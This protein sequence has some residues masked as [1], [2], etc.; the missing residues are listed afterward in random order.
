MWTVVPAIYKVLTAPHIY[1]SIFS[2]RQLTCYWC[3]LD[4]LMRLILHSWCQIQRTSSN[5]CYVNCGPGHIQS[6]YSSAYLGFNIQLK[7]APLLFEVSRRINERITAKLV[8]TTAQI[9][10]LSLCDQWSRTY[11]MY[12]QLRI[13]RPEYSTERICAAIGDNRTYRC[14]LHCKFGVKYS[15]YRPVYA[16]WSVVPYVYNAFTAPH[17]QTTMFIW[18]YLSCYWMVLL[19]VSGQF[20]S[21]Y[22]ANLVP[23]KAH[24]LQITLCELWSRTYTIHLQLRTFRL[25]YSSERICAAIR[26]ISTIQCSSYCK[27][28][29][30]YSAHP[31]V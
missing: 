26:N 7:V 19:Y 23:N 18:T 10:Q 13:F 1:A 5:L 9:L 11:T 12:L 20:N 25:Q 6:A 8:T 16:V 17:I 29:A 22:N 30:K 27:L 15:P 14:A 3:Y 31:P 28:G 2:C 4:N 21:R 24:I